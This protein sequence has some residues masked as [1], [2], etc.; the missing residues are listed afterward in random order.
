MLFVAP[1]G[2]EG[3]VKYPAR[4]PEVMAVGSLN[5]NAELAEDSSTGKSIEVVA[6]GEDVA[7]YGFMD[8]LENDSGTSMAAPQVTALAAMLWQQ[9]LSKSNIFIRNL[10]DA[11]ANNLGDKEAYGY[12]LIDCEKAL[13]EHKGMEMASLDN[14]RSDDNDSPYICTDKEELEGFWKGAGHE[15]TMTLSGKKHPLMMDGVKWPDSVKSG[16]DIATN[17]PEF[18][19]FY[20]SQKEPVNYIASAVYM[21][22]LSGM[23][24]KKDAWKDNKDGLYKVNADDFRRR[25]KLSV[26]KYFELHGK[27][28]NL[29]DEGEL[30]FGMALHTVAD[31]Y[32]HSAW[33]LKI[34]KAERTST[35]INFLLKKWQLLNHDKDSS[36]IPYADDEDY[37]PER[38][39]SA[40][41]VCK[42]MIDTAWLNHKEMNKILY[43]RT[44]HYKYADYKEKNDRLKYLKHA[45]TL[46]KFEDF[47]K[48]TTT[49]LIK[50][51]NQI[52]G[53]K[54]RGKIM[55]W[56]EKIVY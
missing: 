44:E 45:Y 31:M 26:K 25:L 10:I 48:P 42:A 50:L 33:G 55:G 2:N 46:M 38:Y 27:K 14:I 15:K 32:A 35:D 18:H 6:P 22:K 30:I 43:C 34:H 17:N 47:I 11:T 29:A 56:E 51:C 49:D 39:L 21:T 1:A 40:Q 41:N 54:I 28:A 36:A 5:C 20:K 16:V 9:D 52:D 7:A 12:G 13:Q 4:Y 53:E 8:I 3:S 37:I 19:G 23:A 24:S